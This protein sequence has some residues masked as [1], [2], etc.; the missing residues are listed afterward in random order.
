MGPPAEYYPDKQYVWKL[1]RQIYGLRSSPGRW[2]NHLDETLQKE[3]MRR[4]KSDASVWTMGKGEDQ[5][6][7]MIHVDDILMFGKH[8]ELIMFLTKMKKL[9]HVLV[10]LFKIKYVA[11]EYGF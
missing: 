9:S 6:I 8:E 10:L 11:P 3:G 1:K 4:L 2:Q 5:L 7:L